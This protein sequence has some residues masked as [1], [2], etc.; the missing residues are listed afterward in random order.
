MSERTCSIE[1]CD[2]PHE[3]RGWCPAHYRRWRATGDPQ[4]CKIREYKTRPRCT[5]DECDNPNY[6][7]RYCQ[8]HYWRWKRH[9]D[10]LRESKSPLSRLRECVYCT[11]EYQ[12]RRTDQRFCSRRCASL[13]RQG[14]EHK[15]LLA[16]ERKRC[17]RCL[18]I[19]SRTEFYQARRSVDGITHWCKDCLSARSAERNSRP[20]EKRRARENKLRAK[21]SITL[22]DYDRM[23]D[24][25]NHRCR[26][27][28]RPQGAGGK[29]L[30]VDHCHTTGRVRGL[31]CGHCNSGIGMFEDN[32]LRLA[33][34]IAY[35]RGET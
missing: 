15:E 12:P 4:G 30:V 11:K 32:P 22:N 25:Q 17:T 16:Q 2:K 14:D 18:Q 20:E 9:G 29:E 35:L 3:A 19:K 27:C 24:E 26:I 33:A 5:V 31:L 23:L 13:F 21:Y 10:P 8:L 6:G 28:G 7:H 34:A 1:G